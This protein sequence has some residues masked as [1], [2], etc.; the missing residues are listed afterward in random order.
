M[1]I[2]S[3]NNLLPI[4]A[5]VRKSSLEGRYLKSQM[6]DTF[7]KTSNPINTERE[8]PAEEYKTAINLLD[9]M[10][11]KAQRAFDRRT[12]Y[13]G[14]S[15]KLAEKISILWGSKNRAPLVSEDLQI[16]KSQ[17]ERLEI[18]KRTGN[19]K[20]EFFNIFGVNY[21]KEAIKNFENES[22]KY[23]LIKTSEQI[24]EYTDERLST[25]TKF[26]TKH[27]N[28]I[29][30]ESPD[31]KREG[32]RVNIDK[33]LEEF[34]AELTK[35]VGGKENL[36]DIEMLKR[37]DYITLSKEEQIE[38]YTEI[39]EGLIYTS[40]E[41]AKMLKGGKKDKEI[42]KEYDNAYKNAFG[43]NNNIQKRVDKYI[44]TQQ[45]RSTALKD[46]A[47]SGIIGA[48]LAITKTQTPA[49]VGA[50]VSTAGYIGMDLSDLAV[51][52]IPNKEDMGEEIVK[53]IVK[54][55]AIIG[56]EYLV[57]TKMYDV[58]PEAKTCNKHLNNALE[59]ARTL[60]IELS[61]AFVSEYAQTGE[62][63]TYQ[64]NPKDF[65]KITLATFAVEELVLMG[66]SSPAG[67]KNYSPV[68]ISGNAAE[69][70]VKRASKELQK[71]FEKNP[72]Q[73]MNLKLLSLEKPDLFAELIKT[74]LDSVIN[75]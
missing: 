73:F 67:A 42:Q 72:T 43:E 24:A 62:W 48:T 28:S 31:F 51:N 70:V 39:A 50:A 68:S 23:T 41:T 59:A 66:L 3:V 6:P 20:S 45:I 56:L 4:N 57:G 11:G 17:I 30:P 52:K 46:I 26:F 47:M 14:W 33:K 18:A 63:A 29:N 40:K 69:T 5:G 61:V 44:K 12:E 55:S 75:E 8:I 71:N 35:M 64:M 22:A 16:H 32:K 34:K 65:I 21:N 60:G 38:L 58:I 53:D 27:K 9:S 49:L 54:C 10:N 13:E 19:F 25:Y 74:S 15:G 7:E 36:R 1:K 2:C 37:K